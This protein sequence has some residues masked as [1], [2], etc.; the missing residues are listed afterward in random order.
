MSTI[1]GQDAE[2]DKVMDDA[3]ALIH[4]WKTVIEF[5]WR[6]SYVGMPDPFSGSALEERPCPELHGACVRAQ[7]AEAYER[8]PKAYLAA[9]AIVFGTRVKALR[10]S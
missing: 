2:V 1:H 5:E 4:N 6:G 10:Q 7:R 3:Q 8:G 9:D